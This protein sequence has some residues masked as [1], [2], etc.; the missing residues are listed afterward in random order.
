MEGLEKYEKIKDLGEGAQG[1]VILA[2]DTVLGR[3]VAIKSLHASLTR[4]NLH[5]KRFKEEAKTLANLG[6]PS[7]VG[8]YEYVTNN[9]GCHL[10]MEYFEGH[11]LD[12]YIRNVSGP[13]PED[14]AID[15]YIK[16][17]EAMS[18]IHKKNIIHRDIKPSN[19]MINDKS[20]IRLLDFG[21]A[22]NTENDPTLTKVGSSAGYTP[23]YMSPEH[24]NGVPRTKYSDIYS[25]GVTLWQMLT[26]KVPYEEFSQGQI[27]S[28]VANDPL[29]T[30]QSVYENVSLKMN[31]I[32]LKAT[33]KNPKKRY[34]S[35]DDFK[36]EL[37]QLKNHINRPETEFIYNL[38]VKIVN[39]I[40]A[41]IYINKDQHYGTEFTKPCLEFNSESN[42][43]PIEIIVEKPG[44]KKFKKQLF[45]KKDEKLNIKLEKQT[46][47][48][49]SVV[50][51][52]KNKAVPY[53]N[54][55]KPNLINLFV[56]FKLS[57]VW[58]KESIRSKFNKNR[59]E[60][61]EIIERKKIET[62]KEINKKAEG[63]KPHRKEYAVYLVLLSVFIIGVFSV[64]S[65][66]EEQTEV[67][68]SGETNPLN[69]PIVNFETLKTE[70]PESQNSAK[71]PVVLSEPSESIIKIPIKYNGTASNN[72]DYNIK[73]DTLIIQ[74]NQKLGLI[75]LDII[76][77]T[78]KEQD[79]TIII[80]LQ[81]PINATLGD[82]SNYSYTILNDDSGIIVP[83]KSP[84]KRPKKIS[85]KTH[86]TK[87]EK[88]YEQCNGVDLYQY[89]H[90]GKGGSF[91]GSLVRKNST[92]CGFKKKSPVS[93][94][95]E[96]IRKENHDR[97]T[98]PNKD[99]YFITIK[100][101]GK[102]NSFVKVW[103]IGSKFM[104]NEYAIIGKIRNIYYSN[105]AFY[106]NKGEEIL[107]HHIIDVKNIN[108]SYLGTKNIFKRRINFQKEGP[109]L[110][111]KILFK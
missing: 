95:N 104:I 21:I 62:R 18:H 38:S 107:D 24:C 10:I 100:D 90:D 67:G 94:Y 13:I 2:I 22:K 77:D 96:I 63:I 40:K 37:I 65:G 58:A 98:K 71:I 72:T 68:N 87:G 11:P 42:N 78:T 4:D 16:V 34:K 66:P 14:N 20:E 64:F 80:E 56:F 82:K 81:N 57:S 111:N 51:D 23:M 55:F 60:I 70:I 41:T 7:I 97:R 108:R 25:L 29:P 47:L 110:E 52:L 99:G 30:I 91:R 17:L 19:I 43:S 27:Y 3:R 61:I 74:A 109:S 31:D 5:V 28:K 54:N 93:N 45:L 101:R 9:S 59:P 103:K 48:L 83:K 86:P 76:N 36:K 88:Y 105:N 50:L 15:I 1:S 35:C 69:F 49:A 44:Y 12:L 75:E 92:R 84:A 39:E 8:V 46:F 106:T 26:G 33:H 53:M 89:Y 85:K 79:E 102:K 73:S 32:V 6:H